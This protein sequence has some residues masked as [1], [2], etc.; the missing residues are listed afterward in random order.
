[1]KALEQTA[2]PC[3]VLFIPGAADGHALDNGPHVG[4]S[5]KV[6]VHDLG[7]SWLG[8][9]LFQAALGKLRTALHHD[10][11]LEVGEELFVVGGF[12][13]G[14]GIETLGTQTSEPRCLDR[15]E[16]PGVRH[17]GGAFAF[18]LGWSGRCCNGGRQGCRASGDGGLCR[19]CW[20]IGHVRAVG[21]RR[22]RSDDCLVRLR[23]RLARLGGAPS[24]PLHDVAYESLLRTYQLLRA[25][26]ACPEGTDFVSANEDVPLDGEFICGPGLNASEAT[27]HLFVIACESPAMSGIGF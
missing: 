10:H 9:T 5:D 17:G 26:P 13:D 8:G 14:V 2:G 7:C 19:G 3:S 6:D 18:G 27:Q 1:M 22:R 15:L 11:E 25:S 16:L 23:S 24:H 21:R 4:F 12:V 20:R